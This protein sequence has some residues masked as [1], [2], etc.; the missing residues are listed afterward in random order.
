MNW[1]NSTTFFTSICVSDIF[2]FYFTSA[3]PRAKR[4][5]SISQI[6][7][8][9]WQCNV[10]GVALAELMSLCEIKWQKGW[11][12]QDGSY[13]VVVLVVEDEDWWFSGINLITVC[14]HLEINILIRE[15]CRQSFFNIPNYNIWH[16]K[17]RFSFFYE[18]LKVGC[19]IFLFILCHPSSMIPFV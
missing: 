4:F 2:S 18:A 8:R 13:E 17:W 12:C 3:C 15:F 14:H 1:A 16:K 11:G 19:V 9:S 10:V 7:A 5:F 6:W